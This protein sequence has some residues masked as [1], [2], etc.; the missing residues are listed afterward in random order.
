[1]SARQPAASKQRLPGSGATAAALMVISD[2]KR[3][4]VLVSNSS[5]KKTVPVAPGVFKVN[6]WKVLPPE[7]GILYRTVI[8]AFNNI[9]ILFG[10]LKAAHYKKIEE[11]VTAW[12]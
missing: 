3:Q 11:I 9:S 7:V 12:S 2:R 5:R 10:T 1:M 8:Y 4:V 6:V